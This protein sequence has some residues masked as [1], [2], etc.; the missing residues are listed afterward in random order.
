MVAGSTLS[1][2]RVTSAWSY[3]Q[4]FQDKKIARCWY[5]ED[6]FRRKERA[7]ELARRRGV[8]PIQVALA[9]ILHQPFATFPMVG[10]LSLDEVDITC[11]GIGISLT[12]AEVAWLD[13]RPEAAE[14]H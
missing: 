1:R 10:P 12:P 7:D 5:S 9:W 8:Q 11:A 14:A 6:N 3:R 13:L 4:N 2:C